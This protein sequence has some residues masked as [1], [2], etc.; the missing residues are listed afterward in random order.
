[1]CRNIA[2][3]MR[4]RE[5]KNST[6]KTQVMYVCIQQ[7]RQLWNSRFNQEDIAYM[8]TLIL[9]W[10]QCTSEWA[11]KN[12]KRRK[13]INEL[14]KEK[15]KCYNVSSIYS[16]TGAKLYQVSATWAKCCW[17][18]FFSSLPLNVVVV[19]V[20]LKEKRHTPMKFTQIEFAFFTHNRNSS[21]VS[22]CMFVART[23]CY[24]PCQCICVILACR[25][26]ETE[27]NCAVQRLVTI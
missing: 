23:S 7:H 13:N 8:C 14:W 22:V 18:S 12:W 2:A 10:L 21:C 6:K 16:D 24:L 4:A 25:I 26:T 5:P 17:L 11:K 1:M 3:M 20:Q 27:R 9:W 19:V 15:K